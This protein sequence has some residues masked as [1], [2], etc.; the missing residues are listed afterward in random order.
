MTLPRKTSVP[1]DPDVE[2]KFLLL[3]RYCGVPENLDPI[4]RAYGV[5]RQRLSAFMDT[6]RALKNLFLH[7]QDRGPQPTPEDIVDMC[8]LDTDY[9]DAAEEPWS[10]DYGREHNNPGTMTGRISKK[11]GAE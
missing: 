1:L 7:D 6:E 5:S 11:P 3:L 2:E 10:S 4:A 8:G 9:T